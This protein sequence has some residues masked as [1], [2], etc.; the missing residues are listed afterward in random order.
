MGRVEVE[1]EEEVVCGWV[2][3]CPSQIRTGRVKSVMLAVVMK[4]GCRVQ[5]RDVV[6]SEG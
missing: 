3:G 6:I 4:M 2:G 5:L 1:G